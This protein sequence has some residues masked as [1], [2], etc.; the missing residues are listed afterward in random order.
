MEALVTVTE[1]FRSTYDVAQGI[2]AVVAVLLL[3][4]GI[5]D[6]FLDLYYW[7]FRIVY[8][9]KINRYRLEDP[10]LLKATDEKPIAMFIPAWHEYDVIDKMLLNA[11]RTI[12]YANYD[13]FVGVYPNDP[14][15]VAK[16]EEVAAE[17]PHV[18]AVSPATKGP[19]RKPTT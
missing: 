18:H 17:Y 16:V 4:S 11:C 6:L 8:P 2:V 15:T 3:M 9:K 19:R 14:R 7:F 13:I 12:D 10:G 1:F 5:D